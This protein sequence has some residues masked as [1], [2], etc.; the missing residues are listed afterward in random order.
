ME[1]YLCYNTSGFKSKDYV[2]LILLL[3]LSWLSPSELQIQSTGEIT[4]NK[5]NRY[6][7]VKCTYAKNRS[8]ENCLCPKIDDKSKTFSCRCHTNEKSKHVGTYFCSCVNC[9]TETNHINC[10]CKSL[11]SLT[12]KCNVIS[13]T[14]A[15]KVGILIPFT[16][17]F[18]LHPLGHYYHSAVFLALDYINHSKIPLANHS[19]DLLW[20]DTECNKNKTVTLTMKMVKQQQVD[21]I[22]AVGC[23]SCLATAAIAGS[24]NIPMLSTVRVIN[25][26]IIWHCFFPCFLCLVFFK[27]LMID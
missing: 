23:E 25:F 4:L 10:T 26:M 24:N 18:S 15:I 13:N 9:T 2:K 19:L 5:V 21:A 20:G 1:N 27:K 16:H 17:I 14:N 11:T 22:I 8:L 3:W 12:V 7:P 6:V